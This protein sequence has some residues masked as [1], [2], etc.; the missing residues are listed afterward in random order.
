MPVR[1]EWSRGEYTI[2]TDPARLDL[3]LVHE[4]LAQRSYWAREIPRP[5]LER[6]I[7]HALCFGLYGAAAQVGFARVVTDYAV[8]AYLGDVFVVESHRGRGHGTARPGARPLP[9]RW[10]IAVARA[11]GRQAGVRPSR[12]AAK[13]GKVR[14]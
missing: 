7:D 14:P 10:L 5:V 8:F 1:R 9:P 13:R 2:S 4:F 6:S 11:Q 3:D 12:R